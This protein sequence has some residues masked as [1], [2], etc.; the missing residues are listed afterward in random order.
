MRTKVQEA[1][2]SLG[3]ADH[4]AYVQ[5]SVSDFKSWRESNLSEV[6]QFHA[7]YVN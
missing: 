2:L 4:T 7:G 1:Q 6:T 5:S 3:K